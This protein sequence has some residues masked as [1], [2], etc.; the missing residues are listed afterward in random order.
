MNPSGPSTSNVGSHARARADTPESPKQR[1]DRQL[2]ELLNE[3][4]VALPGAQVLFGF[5]LTVPF[6]TRFGRVGHA[7]RVVLLVS[8]L[9]TASGTVLLMGPPVYH[10]LRW[11]RGGKGEVIR[12]AHAMFLTGTAALALGMAAALYLV[13]DVLFGA[14]L[15]GIVAGFIVAVIL[16]TW[17]VIPLTYGRRPHVGDEE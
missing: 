11:A 14:P 16:V 12:V 13:A 5:L 2:T 15:A 17:Y 9:F 7:D 8:L 4:R 1:T 6:A 3:L 10:R